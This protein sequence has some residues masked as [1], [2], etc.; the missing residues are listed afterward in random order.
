[1]AAKVKW[2]S[3]AGSCCVCTSHMSLL[4]QSPLPQYIRH[5]QFQSPPS[6]INVQTFSPLGTMGV[7][8]SAPQSQPRDSSSDHTSTAFVVIS[9]LRCV[10]HALTRLGLCDPTGFG[11]HVVW[12]RA[13]KCHGAWTALLMKST[14][15]I[16]QSLLC[17]MLYGITLGNTVQKPSLVTV[18]I[19]CRWQG[20]LCGEGADQVEQTAA[21]FY[22][23]LILNRAT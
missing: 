3:L 22:F 6:T 17:L 12:L 15:G 8:P 5:H 11:R 4:Q 16:H 20:H 21:E 19:G 1:M 9:V 18:C 2:P 23:S 13:W 7:T 14:W 10:C